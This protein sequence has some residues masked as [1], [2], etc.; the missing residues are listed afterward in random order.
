MNIVGIEPFQ[1]LSTK[2]SIYLRNNVLRSD[3]FVDIVF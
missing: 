1:G 2:A 3:M